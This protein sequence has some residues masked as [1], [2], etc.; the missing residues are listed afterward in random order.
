NHLPAPIPLQRFVDYGHWFQRHAAPDLDT[1]R[2]VQVDRNGKG[3]LV[4]TEDGEVL[5]SRRVVVAAGIAAFANRPQLFNG[6]PPDLASHSSDHGD[7]ARFSNKRVLVV[8]GGQSSLEAAALLRE[9]GADVEVAVRK[10]NVHWLGWK[11]KISRIKT[12]G[13]LLYSPRDVGP[14]GVSQL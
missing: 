4:T 5:H 1:R 12:L 3:F 2:I 14:A 8:G 13:R 9:A 6:L 11:G 7:L 10:P